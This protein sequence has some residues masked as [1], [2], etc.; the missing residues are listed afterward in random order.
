MIGLTLGRAEQAGR[1]RNTFLN[2]QALGFGPRRFDAALA[3]G[4]VNALTSQSELMAPAMSKAADLAAKPQAALLAPRRLLR[5]DPTA[6]GSIQS[7]ASTPSLGR[8][9]PLVRRARL[10]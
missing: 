5:G 1:C 2:P 3:L 6:A 8:A 10:R 4:L 7:R 9:S